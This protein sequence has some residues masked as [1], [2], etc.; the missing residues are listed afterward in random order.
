VGALRHP[1]D[2]CVDLDRKGA[3]HDEDALQFDRK[4]IVDEIV[5]IEI[6]KDGTEVEHVAETSVAKKWMNTRNLRLPPAFLLIA[7]T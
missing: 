4:V 3:D 6:G 1:F 2:N 5:V 7:R